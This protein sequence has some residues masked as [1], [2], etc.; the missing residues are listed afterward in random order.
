MMMV[1]MMIMSH[2]DCGGDDGDSDGED[3]SLHVPHETCVE[4]FKA[5]RISSDD[6][7]VR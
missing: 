5:W 4:G 6:D 2:D 3:E 7:G 1:V